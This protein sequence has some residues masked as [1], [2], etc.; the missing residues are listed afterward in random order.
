MGVIACVRDRVIHKP[1]IIYSYLYIGG[2]IVNILLPQVHYFSAICILK[3]LRKLPAISPQII[4]CS[5][6]PQNMVNGGLL[7]DEYYV[8]PPLSDEGAYVSFLEKI[9]RQCSIDILISSDEDE[10]KLLKKNEHLFQCLLVIPSLKILELFTDKLAASIE[11]N[12]LGIPIPQI[13]TDLCNVDKNRNSKIIF[14]K[15]T[16]VASQGI[17]IADLNDNYIENHFSKDNFIQEYIGG[18]E[19]T[20]DVFCDKNG[21][22]KLAVPRKRL[23]VRNGVT[24]K[25]QIEKNDSIIAACETIYSHYNIPGFSNV[26]FKFQN[27]T[28]YF[29]E[30]N[31][32]FAGTG[33]ASSLASFNIMLPFLE[34]FYY[35]KPLESY[36][37]YMGTVA[38]DSIITRFYE[39]LISL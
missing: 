11:I 32:R 13:Y 16:S 10:L 23:D 34:H 2:A 17:W 39:E 8:S 1:T 27:G 19:Y 3:M 26:Q 25:C 7:V 22:M 37:F 15:K 24:Y 28:P 21:N 29:I 20:V 6:S 12:K 31:P 35:D 5:Q 9:C 14:R 38:W 33:I 36:E 4:G 18:Y 30:L